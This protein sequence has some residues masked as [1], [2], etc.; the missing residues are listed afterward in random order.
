MFVKCVN[1]GGIP[2]EYPYNVQAGTY[3]TSKYWYCKATGGNW[4][5]T[6]SWV[7]VEK[8]YDY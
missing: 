6:S 2:M 3:D 7:G 8:F 1:A 5:T 4:N